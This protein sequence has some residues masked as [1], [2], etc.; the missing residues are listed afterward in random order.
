MNTAELSN[1]SVVI[2]GEGWLLFMDNH[3]SGITVHYLFNWTVCRQHK[4]RSGWCGMRLCC[5]PEGP[6]QEMEKWRCGLTGISWSSTWSSAKSCICGETIPC[7]S[8]WWGHPAGNQLVRKWQVLMETKLN[9]SQQC[10]FAV[11]N[12]NW[13]HQ[14]MY[15][16]QNE[17]GDPSL[18]LTTGEATPGVQLTPRSPE[19][20]L[21]RPN[22][23]NGALA[24]ICPWTKRSIVMHVP[25]HL[26]L[27]PES[28][29]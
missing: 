23:H 5:H 20:T 9:M 11:E 7:T 4:K 17:R 24:S 21:S 15:C 6:W 10:A 19:Q 29:F 22:W 3:H 12:A 26:I 14:T 16:Q 1:C 8:T 2:F 13:L 27:T 25:Y 28:T 18:L